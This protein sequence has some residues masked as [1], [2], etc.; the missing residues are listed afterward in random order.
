LHDAVGALVSDNFYWLSTK[1][2]TLDW[3][4]PADTVYTPQKEFGDLTGLNSLPQVKVEAS[5][6]A[7]VTNGK[8]AGVTKV[9]N[10]SASI[11]FMVHLRLTQGN[12][13]ADVVP[14]FWEDNYFSLLPGEERRV[15]V[16]FNLA[17]LGGVGGYLSLDGYNVEPDTR[18]LVVLKADRAPA[19]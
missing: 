8:L 19:N 16:S 4:H 15:R 13:G 7:S 14:I 6:T 5:I 12:G 3:S 9:K 18:E 2:D 10:N 11:A 17:A 1:A